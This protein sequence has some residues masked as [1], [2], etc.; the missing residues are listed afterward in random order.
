VLATV[1][2]PEAALTRARSARR[3]AFAPTS[4][5]LALSVVKLRDASAE[6]E[7]GVE[8]MYSFAMELT[9]DLIASQP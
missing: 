3:A 5:T 4:W 7:S 2:S 6:V 9:P 8:E 1:S